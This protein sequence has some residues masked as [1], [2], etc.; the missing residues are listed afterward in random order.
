MFSSTEVNITN[1]DTKP[2]GNLSNN[3]QMKFKLD[4][5]Q[6]NS[7]SQYV[8][9]SLL[10]DVIH[11]NKVYNEV[12][13]NNIV[14]L[15]EKYARIEIEQ[16]IPD[17][18]TESFKSYL[19]DNTVELLLSTGNSPLIFASTDK[20]LGI[21][22]QNDGNNVYGISLM[23]YRHILKVHKTKREEEIKKNEYDDNIYNV[24]IV[25]KFLEDKI[26][27]NQDI[28]KYI[29]VKIS[30]I[31]EK[32]GRSR[33]EKGKPDKETILTL[34]NRGGLDPNIV[35]AIK[36]PSKIAV[37]IRKVELPIM[38]NRILRQ[39]KDMIFDAYTDSKIKQSKPELPYTQYQIIKNN[40]RRTTDPVKYYE[41]IDKVYEMYTKNKLP[42]SLV[43][44]IK[45]RL[46][47]LPPIPSEYDILE[48]VNME[49]KTEDDTSQQYV[50]VNNDPILIYPH[51]KNTPEKYKKFV[52]L[53]PYVIQD[54]LM[55]VKGKLFPSIIH[56]LYVMLIHKLTDVSF[57][58]SYKHIL[59][60][61]DKQINN[62]DD[63]VLPTTI[64]KRYKLIM[65]DHT[66]NK[67]RELLTKAI[68]LKFN[69]KR[70]RVLL[71]ATGDNELVF[72]ETSNGKVVNDVI[73][74]DILNSIREKEKNNM[75][76]KTLSNFN[77][78]QLQ[79]LLK[80][81][82]FMNSWLKMRVNDICNVITI[83][84]NYVKRKSQN[85]DLTPELVAL[86]LDIIYQPCSYIVDNVENLSD[87]NKS[88]DYFD[89]IVK[90]CIST[91]NI[92]FSDDVIDIIWK[93]ISIIF[94]FLLKLI[95][96]KS[97]FDL[98]SVLGSIE[99][100]NSSELSC[101]KYTNNNSTDCV[102]SAIINLLNR[103]NNF[104]KELMIATKFDDVE[105]SLVS[106]IIL[107]NTVVSDI[108]SS[109]EYIPTSPEYVPVTSPQ[110]MPTSPQYIPTSPQYMPT[111]PQYDDNIPTS[112]QYDDDIPT[113]PQ[114]DY[115]D[116]IPTSPQY[117]NNSDGYSP[118][119]FIY[120]E[121]LTNN[122]LSGIMTIDIDSININDVIQM[123]IIKEL[124]SIEFS[125]Q[126]V[127]SEKLLEY[128]HIIKD[129]PVN[130]QIK[131]NR[132]NFFATT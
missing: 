125:E 93:R 117:G 126:I 27:N 120:N 39:V 130:T 76:D 36:H 7:I 21:G 129:T 84:Y 77:P 92:E 78:Q 82:P 46:E 128:I 80:V 98:R 33:L 41:L 15:Y 123:K 10:K 22:K 12:D 17:I 11:K 96:H 113:S 87:E 121:E 25:Y 100:M 56:Y 107:S 34:E 60:D 64:E 74:V 57:E 14:S 49:I 99:L 20:S 75:D 52:E 109:P 48:A 19:K 6:W 127:V 5:N 112:P 55:K 35:L 50:P 65:K 110:Y 53:S 16:I 3:A 124:D 31:I 83:I 43:T 9:T 111:S 73:T 108:H 37:I 116:D 72:N 30:K 102:I 81:D 91:K 132:I 66:D 88:P 94:Y 54:N 18:L 28:K 70:L 90:S 71:L 89:A 114:Y 67:K 95:K 69:T 79:S 101:I 62:I 58:K 29:N 106:E 63:F 68:N 131:R 61:T 32:E 42:Q 122:I 104:N 47:T 23:Q 86:I 4:N 119:S 24:Y 38:K 26:K 44:E 8:Y 45:T 118:T 85:I 2:Y 59:R 115:D 97:L 105:F 51:Y 40:R 103:I 13:Y 1:P